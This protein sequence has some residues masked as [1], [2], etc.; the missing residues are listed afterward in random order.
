MQTP[1]VF[2]RGWVLTVFTCLA[3]P[4][5]YPTAM[6]QEA[7][8][9]QYGIVQFRVTSPTNHVAMAAPNLLP[10]Q[11]SGGTLGKTSRTSGASTISSFPSVAQTSYPGLYPLSCVSALIGRLRCC[12][13]CRWGLSHLPRPMRYWEGIFLSG[14]RGP[15][16]LGLFFRGR[17]GRP[18]WYIG[19]SVLDIYRRFSPD[20]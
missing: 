3:T 12:G 19:N 13:S 11:E 1:K 18:Y 8:T 20:S 2:P 4:S 17:C 15:V 14:L 16:Y 5:P 6:F 10:L 9:K 7:A